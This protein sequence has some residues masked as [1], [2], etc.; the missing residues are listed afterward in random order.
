MCMV[1]AA[2]SAQLVCKP[3]SIWQLAEQASAAA[4][5]EWPNRANTNVA[6]SLSRR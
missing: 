4:A 6:A 5:I 3:A 1:L 2:V